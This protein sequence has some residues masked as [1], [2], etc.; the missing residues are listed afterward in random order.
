MTHNRLSDFD[1][2]RPVMLGVAF[3]F[4]RQGFAD[5]ERAA[6]RRITLVLLRQ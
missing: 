4:S 5:D 3:S 1:A 6:L 2:L